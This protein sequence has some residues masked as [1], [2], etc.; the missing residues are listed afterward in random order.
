MVVHRATRG[1]YGLRLCKSGMQRLPPFTN[2]TD[3]LLITGQPICSRHLDL[4][5]LRLIVNP[6][7]GL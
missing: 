1:S 4:D 6:K 5:G 7:S 3:Y 2:R